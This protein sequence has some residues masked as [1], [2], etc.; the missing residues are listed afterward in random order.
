VVVNA[1]PFAQTTPWWLNLLLSFGP[2]VLLI[3]G[4][5]WLSRRAGQ[6]AGGGLFGMGRSKAKRYDE[7]LG[8]TQRI[9]FDDV[10]GIDEAKGE[11]V[12]IVDF[13]RDPRKYT[14]LGGSVP[15]GVLLVGPPGTGKTLLAR[16]VAGEAKV[17]FFSMGA[18]E[19]VEMIVGV[20][21]SRVRDLFKQ[22]RDAAPAIIFIDEL[23]AIGRARGGSAS[24]GAN[25]EQEQTLNQILTE[26]DGFSRGEAVIVLAATN[27][28]DVLDHALLRPGRF[29][30]RVVVQPPDR[31]GRAAILKV[32]TRTVPL[33]APSSTSPRARR[34]CQAPGAHTVR[35]RLA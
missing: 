21:A 13:L 9:T 6:A 7:T 8:Q 22:A 19:F 31:T 14:R 10:A 34:A 1:T 25:S 2:I 33:A 35:R 3:G 27:R 24:F 11:L 16:A 32:H 5:V 15:R 23:D 4:F 18:S 29:D 12:E 26:M 28:S 30:R 20:G 17:P